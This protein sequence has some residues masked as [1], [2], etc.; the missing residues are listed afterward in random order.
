MSDTNHTPGPWSFSSLSPI[1]NG[2]I[3]EDAEETKGIATV[4]GSS[5]ANARLIAAAPELLC[6]L[7]EAVEHAHVYDTNPALKELFMA[8]IQKATAQ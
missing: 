2:F 8:V 7:I 3:I 5:E 6:V 4:H 1:E